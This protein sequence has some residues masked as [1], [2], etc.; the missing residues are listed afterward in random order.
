M[1]PRYVELLIVLGSWVMAS[2]AAAW[3]AGSGGEVYH[4]CGPS[5]GMCE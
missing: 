3:Y 2:F 1:N 5:G 4:G